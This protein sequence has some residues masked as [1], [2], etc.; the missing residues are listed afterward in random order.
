MNNKKDYER[1]PAELK[2]KYGEYKAY[3]IHQ[4]KQENYDKDYQKNLL[5][6]NNAFIGL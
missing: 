1:I 6:K 2:E 5:N 4:K 3:E